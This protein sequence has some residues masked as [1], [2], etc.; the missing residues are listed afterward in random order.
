[1]DRWATVFQNLVEKV[2][3]H[4]DTAWEAYIQWYTPRTRA[5]VMYVP[6]PQPAASDPDATRVLAS[7]VYP[8]RRDQHYDTTVSY[9]IHRLS[10]MVLYILQFTN[11]F[12]AVRHDCGPFTY[13]RGLDGEAGPDVP[14]KI[15]DAFLRMGAITSRFLA[16]VNYHD[17]PTL[18]LFPRYPQSSSSTASTVRSHT[19]SSSSSRPPFQA[20][21][22]PARPPAHPPFRMSPLAG[23]PLRGL[24]PTRAPAPG[25]PG[26]APRGPASAPAPVPSSSLGAAFHPG[27]DHYSIILDCIN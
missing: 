10:L 16:A 4:D 21:F 17:N 9:K 5:R 14:P 22:Y 6:P 27:I 24:A 25:G 8:V 19:A 2:R 3:P 7:T 26:P 20:A 13:C 11:N 1:V 23:S 15:S 12:F 18:P